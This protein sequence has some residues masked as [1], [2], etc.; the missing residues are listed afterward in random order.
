M[1]LA[2]YHSHLHATPG[3]VP[4][5]PFG[6]EWYSRSAV[7][8]IVEHT[9]FPLAAEPDWSA[10][11]TQETLRLDLCFYARRFVA[12]VRADLEEH[13]KARASQS[14]SGRPPNPTLDWFFGVLHSEYAGKFG[15]S[16]ATS[17]DGTTREAVGPLV[18]FTYSSCE[19]LRQ[20]IDESCR[21]FD[22]RLRDELRSTLEDRK[23]GLTARAMRSR[24]DR[25]RW[26]RLVVRIFGE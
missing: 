2:E 20:A 1:T 19:Q 15:R 7:H 11:A 10:A 5:Q 26:T 14:G 4:P 9:G 3:P 8:R 25:G 21:F 23:R 16:L 18:R 24:L 6:R 12:A 13:R 17:T 22:K